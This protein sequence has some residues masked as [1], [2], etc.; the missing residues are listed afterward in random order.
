VARKQGEV[1]TIAADRIRVAAALGVS[2]KRLTALPLT[3]V[4]DSTLAAM[5]HAPAV[6]FSMYPVKE[7]FALDLLYTALLRLL[8]IHDP[9][10]DYMGISDRDALL[11]VIANALAELPAAKR[12][13]FQCELSALLYCLADGDCDYVRTFALER[14]AQLSRAFANGDTP[15][16][17]LVTTTSGV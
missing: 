7:L 3:Q 10:S 11:G 17:G 16:D 2:V 13:R 6:D 12:E 9:L 5:K 1:S 15:P 4:D 14:D 8:D